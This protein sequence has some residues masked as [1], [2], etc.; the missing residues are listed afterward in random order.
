MGHG[1]TEHNWKVLID[2]QQPTVKKELFWPS[3][4][5]KKRIYLK[6]HDCWCDSL[7][8]YPDILYLLDLSTDLFGWIDGLR[9]IEPT[10][11]W[12]HM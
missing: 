9:F 12:S 2:D 5:R 3:N 8:E 11:R 1:Y 6:N 10:D 4:G 7:N